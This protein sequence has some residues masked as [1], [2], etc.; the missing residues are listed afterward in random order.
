MVRDTQKIFPI[1]GIVGPTSNLLAVLIDQKEW[2]STRKLILFGA[3]FSIT[4][5]FISS[6]VQTFAVFL[7]VFSISLGTMSFNKTLI[8]HKGWLFFPGHEGKVTGFVY[9][10]FGLGGFFAI[11]LSTYLVNPNG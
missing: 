6:F 1:Q 8:L 11:V 4:G 7:Y 3:M 5:V 2:C 10:G 9:A